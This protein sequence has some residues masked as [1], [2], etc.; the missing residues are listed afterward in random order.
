MSEINS[1]AVGIT[2]EMIE[3]AAIASFNMLKSKPYDRTDFDALPEDHREGWLASARVGL[4]AALAGRTVVEPE[5][6]EALRSAKDTIVSSARDWSRHG[7]DAWLWGLLCGWDC[8]ERHEHDDLCGG[9]PSDQEQAVWGMAE[10]HGWTSQHIGRLRRLRAVI[11]AVLAA[12]SSEG[13]DPRE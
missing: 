11:S 2:E 5:L 4:G 9:E 10:R 12:E 7:G 8:E 13:G 3:K 6:R 1:P